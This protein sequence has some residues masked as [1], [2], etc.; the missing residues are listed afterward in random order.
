MNNVN[1]LDQNHSVRT[2]F[3][4]GASVAKKMTTKI[5]NNTNWQQLTDYVLSERFTW[6]LGL[7]ELKYT[8]L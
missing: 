3:E 5:N 2:L 7:V 8:R 4:L 6:G 1:S